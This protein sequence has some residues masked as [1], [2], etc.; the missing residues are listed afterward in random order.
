MN[1]TLDM[2][3]LWAKFINQTKWSILIYSGD[4]DSAVPTIGKSLSID[5]D[6]DLSL[7]PSLNTCIHSYFPC[8]CVGLCRYAEVDQ[9]SGPACRE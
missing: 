7:Y 8:V 5:I 3:P 9:L 4:V 2:V 6:M 1:E